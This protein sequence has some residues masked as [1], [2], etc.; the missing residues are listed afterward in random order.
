M[1]KN[2]SIKIDKSNNK[3]KIVDINKK[4]EPPTFDF[5]KLVLT[6]TKSF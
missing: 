4:I 2:N 6:Q 3:G 5:T 1:E